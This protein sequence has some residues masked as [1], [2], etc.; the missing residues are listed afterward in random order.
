MEG[1]QTGY[2]SA[3]GMV[4]D[5]PVESLVTV[6]NALGATVREDLSNV[7]EV[8]AERMAAHWNQPVDPC[9]VFWEGKRARLPLRLSKDL[10]SKKGVIKI[11]L[12]SGGKMEQKF[13]LSRVRA[14]RR[15]KTEDRE[16]AAATLN[17][18]GRF[19]PGYHQAKITIGSKTYPL[20]IIAAPRRAYKPAAS[21]AP[22]RSTGIFAPLYALRSQGSWG[23]GDFGDLKKL[24]DWSYS[25]GCDFVGTLPMLATFLEKPTVEPSPYSP[26]SR[27][28]WNEIYVD[29]RATA[30]WAECPAAQQIAASEAFRKAVA[31]QQALMEVDYLAVYR[32]KRQ[33]LEELAETFFNNGK[34]S[35]S[36]FRE[37]LKVQPMAKD[38]AAFRAVCDRLNKSWQVW[39]EH[40][41][42]GQIER[43]D[44]S[45]RDY[46]FHLYS[47]YLAHQQLSELSRSSSRNK[48]RGIY[49][50]F[51]LSA[52]ASGYDVWRERD[53]FCHVVSAGCPP[54]PAHVHG[55]DWG[56]LPLNP[57]S[58]RSNG[59]RYVRACLRNHMRY[60]GL[61]RLDHVMCF[62]RL[63]WVPRGRTAKEGV[64]IRY[65]M[66]EFFALLC[67]E[68]HRNRCTLIGEDLGTV[69]PEIRAAM[70]RHGILRMYCQ[71]R[72]LAPDP[73]NS[74]APVPPNCICSLNTHDM[75]P[76]AAFWDGLDLDDK[77][78]LGY[79]TPQ[80]LAQK[81]ADRKKSREILGAYLKK[82][83]L[84][85]DPADLREVLRG[86]L[87]M[88]AGGAAKVMQVNIEDLWLE[89]KSQ[90]VPG[91]WKERPNWKRKLK[92][93]VEE[94]SEL[95][96]L[97][98][99]PAMFRQIL[100]LRKGAR[101]Y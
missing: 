72:R 86:M 32:L 21:E 46:R 23:I 4:L 85:K 44:Y 100:K 96:E 77:M 28:F 30:E 79:F 69:P 16:Y 29:P 20:L 36:A 39:P 63:F 50:D 60:T 55:Q 90:N 22:A 88:T 10:R 83:K 76:F 94:W 84:I 12:E 43:E 89:T 58:I 7:D 93:T 18:K 95:N 57:K 45:A 66:D 99:I 11:A 2:Q 49:L 59:Y 78:K 71:Q 19:K 70:Q 17:I 24:I 82:R 53:S 98:G 52:H 54:D 26:A 64:Y 42:E 33:V 80:Q 38:Y 13:D 92:H 62:Y 8:H 65:N 101:K 25:L 14:G 68:S 9:V 27:T 41:R 75:P 87:L 1:V 31:E 56:I 61:L 47:Q 6:L 34:D 5:A 97:G 35:K 15:I 3:F 37:F 40:L 51:P 73:K 48:K 91:T 67:L 81:H 74:L